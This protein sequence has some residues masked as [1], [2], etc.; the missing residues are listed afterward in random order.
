MVF[1]QNICGLPHLCIFGSAFLFHS[2]QK[3][4]N[5]TVFLTMN[6]FFTFIFNFV[7]CLFSDTVIIFSWCILYLRCFLGG[8]ACFKVIKEEKLVDFIFDKK[9][10]KSD[11][12]N[13][14]LFMSPFL[15]FLGQ[16]TGAYCK[17]ITFPPCQP[18]ATL[19]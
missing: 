19:F 14:D 4:V 8:T 7:H 10:F 13:S 15:H 9:M 2:S 11:C 17:Y 3:D 18:V 6:P 5:L 1:L 16:S 12:Q